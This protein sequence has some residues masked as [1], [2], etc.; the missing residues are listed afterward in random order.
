MSEKSWVES[1]RYLKGLLNFLKTS[2]CSAG[3]DRAFLLVD[4]H[5]NEHH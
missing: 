4:I 1:L 3:W 2:I 5:G